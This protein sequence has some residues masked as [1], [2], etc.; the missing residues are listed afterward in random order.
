MHAVAKPSLGRR[1]QHP[2]HHHRPS[3]LPHL[4]LLASLSCALLFCAA[5]VA[6]DTPASSA[7][8]PSQQ[9]KT[10]P[11]EDRSSQKLEASKMP[12][13]M[14]RG[15][16]MVDVSADVN[17]LTASAKT[18]GAKV[19]PGKTP[20]PAKTPA[21]VKTPPA[22]ASKEFR[23]K[24]SPTDLKAAQGRLSLMNT[25]L[26]TKGK[27]SK[28]LGY[29]NSTGLSAR[30]ANLLPFF[31]ITVMVPQDSAWSKITP[32]QWKLINSKPDG[33]LQLVSFHCFFPAFTGT[34]LTNLPPLTQISTADYPQRGIVAWKLKTPTTMFNGLNSDPQG[35]LL[36]DN[37]IY[38]DYFGKNKL[39]AH[40]V[41]MVMM[42]AKFF[43][44]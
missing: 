25:I 7:T 40:G 5:P 44:P 2:E 41:N 21:P 15:K 43:D 8:D 32:A 6:S 39:I 38:Y 22:P 34:D 4:L 30:L 29:L 9:Q 17:T 35:A 13:D 16:T 11:E 42:P 20:A 12:A 24:A 33:L 3:S 37:S 36:M 14:L 26:K 1:R 18:A 19:P 28:F 10:T 27:Y 31:G 23:G